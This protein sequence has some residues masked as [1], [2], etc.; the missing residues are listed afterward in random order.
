[1]ATTRDTLK[2][3]WHEIRP[4]RVS[5][6]VALFCIPISILA[7]NTLVSYFFS[8]AIGRL[9]THD[10]GSLVRDLILAGGIGIF[11]FIL[12]YIGFQAFTR[13]QAVVITRA[14]DSVFTRLIN[15]DA[16]FFIDEKLGG[17]TSKYIDFVRS[18]FTVEMLLVLRS[19]GLILSLVVGLALIATQSVLVMFILLALMIAL[20]IEVRWVLKLRAPYREARKRLRSEIHGKVAD[21]VTNSL[22]VKTFVGENCEIREVNKLGKEFTDMYFKDSK[23]WSTEGSLRVLAMVVIQIVAISVSAYLASVGTVNVGTVIFCLTYLQLVGSQIFSIG[24]LVNGYEESL[25]EAAPMTDILLRPNKVNDVRRATTLNNITPTITLENVSYRYDDNKDVVLDSINLD[26][27]AGQKIGLVGHSGAGKTTITQLLL[28]FNDV[29]AGRIMVDGHDISQVTQESLRKNISY[30]P[31]EPML[32]HRSLRDN[33]SYGKPDATDAE[34][35]KAAKQANALEFIQTLPDGFETHVGERGVKL[36]GGQRQRVAIARAILKDAP[37]LILDEATSALDS[38]SEKL[39]QD[40]LKKLMKGRTSIVIAHRLSTIATL[41]RIV[42][43]EGGKVIE[44]GTHQ[45]LLKHKGT[46][47]KLWAHQS[48]GFIEE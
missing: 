37:I 5:F 35:T 33:I 14:R 29:T 6:F 22:V 1:M 40:A 11:G 13:H 26:I 46:Y 19:I 20:I 39:I 32:F 15:K 16:R 21:S 7:I 44:D 10:N 36:S 45:E 47:A 27:P 2:L 41:D 9:L 23:I 48:G 31:Q 30:V 3:F 12:N 38:E 4:N 24:D 25:V 34:I 28:R 8:Q 18:I 17:L 42:V 43:L